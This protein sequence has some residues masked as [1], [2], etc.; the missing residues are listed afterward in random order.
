M[1][2]QHTTDMVSL[3]NGLL[4]S[5]AHRIGS[6]EKTP[7]DLAAE[8][9]KELRPG[10][11]FSFYRGWVDEITRQREP[12]CAMERLIRRR[13]DEALAH[14]KAFGTTRGVL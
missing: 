1:R 9:A 13:Y 11:S 4:A 2:T 12:N 3:T 5:F 14:F 8:T 7:R 10:L 6:V